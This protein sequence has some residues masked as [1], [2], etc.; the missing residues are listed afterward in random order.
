VQPYPTALGSASDGTVSAH[1]DGE[2]I[3]R[4]E[5]RKRYQREWSREKR[6]AQKQAVEELVELRAQLSK[7]QRDNAALGAALRSV[8]AIIGELRPDALHHPD[9]QTA[10]QQLSS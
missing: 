4:R 3:D 7:M 10:I 6:A 5:A 8:L 1:D 2:D 9:V